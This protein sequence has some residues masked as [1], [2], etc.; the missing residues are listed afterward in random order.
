[1][2]TFVLV[3]G[4]W[5]GGWCWWK[6]APLLRQA[7]HEVYTPTLTGL[8]ERTHL[9]TRETNLDTHITDIV[10]VLEYEELTNVILLGHSYSGMVI[11][12]VADRV[13]HRLAHLVH[14]DAF[15]PTSGQSAMGILEPPRELSDNWLIQPSDPTVWGI[16][17]P[18]DLRRVR[19]HIVGHPLATGL[20]ALHLTRPAGAG[21]PRTYIY[22][23]ANN[24]FTDLAARLRTDTTWRYR[25]IDTGHDA[26][27]T[28]PRETADLLLE[29]AALA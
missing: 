29:I 24:D 23:T 4:G 1:V 8:G 15:A 18:E 17:D 19:A 13:P 7:G 14:L 25:E 6:V 16:T 12:G 10:N 28:Q 2:A 22:C 26:M 9:A 27:I 21:L 11:T 3:H 20:Q 5:H